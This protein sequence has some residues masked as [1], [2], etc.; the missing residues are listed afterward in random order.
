M[1][2]K[3]IQQYNLH[4]VTLDSRGN[5]ENLQCIA[6]ENNLQPFACID[7]G[8]IMFLVTLSSDEEDN[9]DADCDNDDDVIGWDAGVFGPQLSPVPTVG[10]FCH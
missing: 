3:I 6:M 8:D 4:E 7:L 10:A 1:I 2:K 9:Y 5:D